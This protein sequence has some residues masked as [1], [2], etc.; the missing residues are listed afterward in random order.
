MNNE[1]L[2]ERVALA[3]NEAGLSHALENKNPGIWLV[4]Y[5]TCEIIAKAAI[6]AMGAS[7]LTDTPEPQER[8]ILPNNAETQ[9]KA[10]TEASTNGTLIEKITAWREGVAKNTNHPAALYAID[11][12]VEVIRRDGRERHS[13]I[14]L[15][16]MEIGFTCERTGKRWKF[17][18]LTKLIEAFLNAT[19]PKQEA[20]TGEIR[21]DKAALQKK[22]YEAFDSDEVWKHWDA[23]NDTHHEVVMLGINAIYNVIEPYLTKREVV[24]PAG[25]T[26]VPNKA[27]KWLFGEEGEFA[28]PLS[29][30]PAGKFWWRSAFRKMINSIEGQEP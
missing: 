11:C 9:N 21:L 5:A 26:L 12:I 15:H 20:P 1:A 19:Q 3:I 14:P 4:S 22:M 10:E 30:Y 29:S 27:L 13:E 8:G 25:F 24:A 17:S 7:V 23:E 16:E 2:I 28:P 6:A 18:S